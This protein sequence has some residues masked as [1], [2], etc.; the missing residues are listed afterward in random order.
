MPPLNP[1]HSNP[2][3]LLQK[4]RT[5]LQRRSSSNAYDN[6][7][8]LSR[9]F[10]PTT[11][12]NVTP[13]DI[14]ESGKVEK[15]KGEKAETNNRESEAREPIG[16]S[17]KLMFRAGLI[18][19]SSSGIYSLLPFALRALEKLERIVDIEMRNIGI[20]CSKVNDNDSKSHRKLKDKKILNNASCLFYN[21]DKTSA[22]TWKQTGRWNSS[23]K[24]IFRLQDRKDSEFCLAPTHEEEITKLIAQEI[25][26]YRQLPL[27]LYQIDRK[28]RDE[29]RPR[30]GLLRAREFIMKDLYTFDATE[31]AS[32]KTYTEVTEA[33]KR[34]FL[35]IGL[36]FIIADA[37]SGNI[38]GKRSHE[39]HFLSEAGEDQI[40]S[41]SK[42]GYIANEEIA[43]GVL[44]RPPSISNSIPQDEIIQFGIIDDQK[45]AIILMGKDRE[46]NLLKLKWGSGEHNV[47]LL[48]P[49]KAYEALSQDS[50]QDPVL[51]IFQDDTFNGAIQNLF[52]TSHDKITTNIL[53]KFRPRLENPNYDQPH[54]NISV[55]RGDYHNI[56]AGDGCPICSLHSHSITPSHNFQPLNS[57][58]GIEV[59]HTF[60]LGTKYSDPLQATYAPE[61]PATAGEHRLIQMGCF[62]LG[63]TRILAAI[64]EIS[65]DKH[66]IIWPTAIAP[67]RVCII[68]GT[69]AE[70]VIQTVKQIYDD[71]TRTRTGEL[72]ND[73]VIDDRDVSFG[74]RMKDAQLVGYPWC[75]IIGNNFLENGKVEIQKRSTNDDKMFVEIA[76][77]GK[78]ILNNGLL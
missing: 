59:G 66:G 75:I 29:M 22:N 63:L 4:F 6:R 10:S 2:G 76:E 50:H 30:S 38:G 78:M 70:T 56:K 60:L 7:I 58:R 57:N 67:Y 15:V 31:E 72:E 51:H 53:E 68:P 5:S 54:H 3:I 62:G 45:L 28:Y 9:L 71:L 13:S 47:K 48:N 21:R 74:Y 8:C 1:N 43:I 69:Q 65:H 42:C 40:I 34:I 39:Y 20:C 19:Q 14:K 35:K 12:A 41:C 61:N 55:H 24:E 64:I 17:Y 23:G 32:I 16:E 44:P 27:K 49:L 46:V 25:S 33:Y 11:K 36:P 73:V 18:R 77:I 37:D 52:L 26:S